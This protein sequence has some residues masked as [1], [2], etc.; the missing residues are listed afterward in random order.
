MDK[1][2]THNY[3]E[4]LVSVA[5]GDV[6]LEGNLVIPDA[7]TG[8]VV[9]AHGS[10]S[11]RH[12]PRNRYV[13]GVLQQA[14]LATLLIDL[15]THQEEA[16]D[17]ITRNLRFDIELLASRLVNATDWLIQNPETHHL[18]VGYFGASTGGGAAL[19]AA[20]KHPQAVK[21][22]V[23]RGGRPD[24]AGSALPHVQAPTLLIVGGYDTQVIAM[25]QDALKQLSIEKQLEIIPR[26]T[27][28]F[29]EPVALEAVAKLA[30]QWFTHYLAPKN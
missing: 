29:E 3:R 16:I 10:G 21:A 9:F 1:T 19:V 30:S 12:S 4:H 11:S 26:A 20:A 15:L 27:H 25:N 14:G 6:K 18:Q 28:L 23:S 22:V 17:L 7:A 8:I 2:S 13:A 5:A 24:L